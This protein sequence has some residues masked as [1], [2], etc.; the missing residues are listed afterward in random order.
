MNPTKSSAPIV[1][2]MSIKK[3]IKQKIH[4]KQTSIEQKNG[5]KVYFLSRV[6]VNSNVNFL[7]GYFCV[8]V[9]TNSIKIFT[10]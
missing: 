7:K 10:S 5:K 9:E 4:V 3:N 2:C 6:T 8:N 1:L